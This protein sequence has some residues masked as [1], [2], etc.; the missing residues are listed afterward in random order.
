MKLPNANHAFVDIRKLRDYCLNPDHVRGQHKARVFAAVL[1]IT[2][3]DAD[4]LR[5]AILIGVQSADAT[6]HEQDAYGQR[7]NV[8]IVVEGPKGQ[9]AVRTI[10]IIRQGEDFPRLA[11]CYVL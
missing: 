2:A 5:R 9:A 11:S 6:L 4:Q 3:D 10:W 1:G 7:Y 8:D